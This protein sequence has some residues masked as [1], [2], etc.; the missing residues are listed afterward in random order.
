MR[1]GLPILVALLLAA[2]ARDPLEPPCP[3]VSA[4]DLV[5]SEVRGAQTG[6]ADTFGQWVEIY[7]A[8]GGT[9]S[10][11]GLALAMRRLDGSSEARILVRSL[12]DEVAAG[13]YAVLG[14]FARGGE[15]THVTYGFVA[16]YNQNLFGAAALELSACGVL[17]DRV[18][19]RALPATG[20][21]AF[22]G[23]R[24]PDA[25]ANDDERAWCADA[26]GTGSP[27]TPLMRNTPCA[28]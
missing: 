11:G 16:D 17:I 3:Q 20:S 13:G 18:V 6:S 15:P 23:G 10:L 8:S 5:L 27:G 12:D 1:S 22:D 2:C 21:L 25:R 4:G 24:V 14:R 28:P 19:Y 26:S 7:N 9:V